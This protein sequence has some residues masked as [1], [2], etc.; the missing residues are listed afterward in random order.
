MVKIIVLSTLA[1]PSYNRVNENRANIDRVGSISSSWIDDKIA[2]LSKSK[3]K[4]SFRVGFF[5]F[6]A[7]LAFIQLKKAFIKA[8]IPYHFNLKCHIQTEIDTSGYTIGEVLNQLTFQKNLVGKMIYKPNLDNLLSKI[9]QWYVVAFF[10]KK[11]I[12]MK[13]NYKTYNSKI[14]AIIK[15]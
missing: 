6:E 4:I 15:A 2:N 10:S 11:M 7:S 3:K 5:T 1:R 9:G 8:P 14:L 13:T 12:F